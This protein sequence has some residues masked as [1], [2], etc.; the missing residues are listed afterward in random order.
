VALL[1][2]TYTRSGDLIANPA[3][4]PTITKV[5]DW[6]GRR[7]TRHLTK[8]HHHP[9]TDGPQRG[10]DQ[11]ALVLDLTPGPGRGG[12]EPNHLADWI[13]LRRDALRPR[14]FLLVAVEAP[15]TRGAFTD[16]A[17]PLITAARTAGLIYHQHLVVVHAPLHEPDPKPRQAAPPGRLVG[18]RHGRVHSDL[19]AF[20]S[21]D[22]DE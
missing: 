3:T 15:A 16:R 9:D 6:L 14:G 21:G 2:A 18:G 11:A 20:T 17:T 19:Y 10:T 4:D 1:V 13:R 12:L 22:V 8:R 7:T 5:A